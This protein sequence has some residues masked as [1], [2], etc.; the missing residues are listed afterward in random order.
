ML[1]RLHS[2]ATGRRSRWAVIA[3]W[4]ALAAALLPLHSK[5]QA[6]AEDESDTFLVRGSQSAEVDRLLDERFDFGSDVAT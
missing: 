5:L 6:E 1:A 4:I 2:L 3:A